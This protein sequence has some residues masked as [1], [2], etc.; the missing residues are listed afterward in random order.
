MDNGPQGR[1]GARITI[2]DYNYTDLFGFGRYIIVVQ[3]A[4][5]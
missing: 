4:N 1:E 2:Q 3:G 5:K